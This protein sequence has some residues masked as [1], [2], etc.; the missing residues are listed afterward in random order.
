MWVAALNDS[1]AHHKALDETDTRNRIRDWE[2][3]WTRQT[4]GRFATQPHSD[5]ITISE[6]LYKKYVSSAPASLANA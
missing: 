2:L 1:L 3:G 6:K 4:R 5:I